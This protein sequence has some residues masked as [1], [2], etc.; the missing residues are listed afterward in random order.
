MIFQ[1]YRELVWPKEAEKWFGLQPKRH[2]GKVIP[3]PVAA[4]ASG[5]REGTG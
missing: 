3:L 5:N 4:V 1:H 2:A